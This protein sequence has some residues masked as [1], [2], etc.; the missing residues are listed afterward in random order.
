VRPNELIETKHF[1]PTDA[2]S[3]TVGGPGRAVPFQGAAAYVVHPIGLWNPWSLGEWIAHPKPLKIKFSTN[4]FRPPSTPNFRDLLG[5]HL[6]FFEPR[7]QTAVAWAAPK[8]W[9]AYHIFDARSHAPA[10]ECIQNY[11]KSMNFKTLIP[12]S[13]I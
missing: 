13:K 12:H 8:G 9:K 11:L 7:Q 4:S 1:Q 2:L 10:W 3:K 5:P 6:V